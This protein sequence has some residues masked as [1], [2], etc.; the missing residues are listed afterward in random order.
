LDTRAH[1]RSDKPSVGH[2][3]V[4]LLHWTKAPPVEPPRDIKVLVGREVRKGLWSYP[5]LQPQMLVESLPPTWPL[6]CS[7]LHRYHQPSS[8]GINGGRGVTSGA[9]HPSLPGELEWEPVVKTLFHDVTQS[10]HPHFPLDSWH[11]GQED[12]GRDWGGL[13]VLQ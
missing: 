6:P 8:A 2:L 10:L 3:H 12:R 9:G 4:S 5:Q 1:I 11:P 7:L 13:P